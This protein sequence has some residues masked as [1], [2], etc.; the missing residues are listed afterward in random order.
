M[1]FLSNPK[2][3]LPSINHLL[4]GNDRIILP[5]GVHREDSANHTSLSRA[6]ERKHTAITAQ[7]DLRLP[8]DLF[9]L[10]PSEFTFNPFTS[11]CLHI[12]IELLSVSMLCLK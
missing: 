11:H 10:S 2:K 5:G 8:G 7:D 12:K 6:I 4:N 1:I 9:H 3:E